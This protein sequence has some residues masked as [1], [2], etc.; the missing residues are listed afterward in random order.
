MLWIAT[1]LLLLM[2][3]QQTGRSS[4]KNYAGYL[5][6]QISGDEFYSVNRYHSLSAMI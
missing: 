6:L 5:M 3:I 1:V 4:K 2:A